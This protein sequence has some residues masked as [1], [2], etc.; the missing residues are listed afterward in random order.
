MRHVDVRRCVFGALGL[1]LSA[2]FKE[3]NEVNGYNSN[4]NSSW[5]N[6]KL[7]ISTQYIGK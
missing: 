2:R 6:S 1:W 5:F 3:T 4:V 7:M